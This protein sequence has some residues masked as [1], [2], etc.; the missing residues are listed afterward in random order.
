MIE[1]EDN[2]KTKYSLKSSVIY[3]ANASGKTTVLK[4]IKF[5]RFLLNTS[6]EIQQGKK[7]NRIPFKL[8]RSCINK[9]SEFQIIFKFED[10][11]Y[12]Y[13]F[14][15]TEKKVFDEYLYYY[16]NRRQSIIFER[17]DTENYKFNIDPETQSQIK[18]RNTENKLYLSTAAL[19]NYEKVKS[20]F[21]WLTKYLQ[22]LSTD[23]SFEGYTADL[24]SENS[25]EGL[26]I[27]NFLKIADLGIDNVNVL[28]RNISDVLK[29]DMFNEISDE[30]KIKLLSKF[31]EL[32]DPE[33]M[34]IRTIHLGKDEKFNPIEI[35]FNINE[36]SDGTQRFLGLLGPW[37]DVLNNGYTLIVDE[38]DI[39]LHTL[40]T[41]ALIKLFH[42]PNNT[43]AQLIFST[44]DTNLLDQDIFRRDQ[45]W[46][47]EKKE[48]KSTDLYSLDDFTVRKDKDIE[49]G[50]LQGKYG[51]IPFF[52]GD[53][54]WQY[55]K[56]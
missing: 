48:D 11:K 5:M 7:I 13:G 22:V 28:K 24:I 40:L 50:Y 53:W 3:G 32:E 46:F 41:R 19:W 39:K 4:A 27:K 44:H 31:K 47:T 18:E 15:V 10:I 37:I 36:E 38:L 30:E 2:K 56:I 14:S 25:K 52:K 42:S 43:N 45:I 26:L 34:D 51:A 17:W 12:A 20:P 21:K 1:Y 54:L 23:Q 55:P 9:P 16:P 8:D 49:K 6:H 35:Q 29:D 33:I